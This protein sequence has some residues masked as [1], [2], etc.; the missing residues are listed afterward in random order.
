MFRFLR[1]ENLVKQSQQSISCPAINSPQKDG[2][3]PSESSSESDGEIAEVSRKQRMFARKSIRRDRKKQKEQQKKIENNMISM[4]DYLSKQAEFKMWLKEEKQ[5]TA[6]DLKSPKLKTYFKDFMKLWNKKKLPQK[7]YR[8]STGTDTPPPSRNQQRFSFV[9][10]SPFSDIPGFHH[11]IDLSLEGAVLLDSPFS[12]FGKSP[13]DPLT[14]Q[15]TPRIIKLPDIKDSGAVDK[16][17][18]STD[19]NIQKNNPEP[20]SEKKK[21]KSKGTTPKK[22]KL[23]NDNPYKVTVLSWTSKGELNVSP[24]SPASEEKQ[25]K[26]KSSKPKPPKR[27][28]QSTKVRLDTSVPYEEVKD[29]N[30]LE[31]SDYDPLYADPDPF[32]SGSLSVSRSKSLDSGLHVD[33]PRPVTDGC[34]SVEEIYAVPVKKKRMSAEKGKVVEEVTSPPPPLPPKRK[35]PLETWP[36]Q[37]INNAEEAPVFSIKK[38]GHEFTSPAKISNGSKSVFS[39]QKMESPMRMAVSMPDLCDPKL[40]EK[41]DVDSSSSSS[42]EESE[43]ESFEIKVKILD[44]EVQAFLDEDLSTLPPPPDLVSDIY[45]PVRLSLLPPPPPELL[46]DTPPMENEYRPSIE[47]YGS[48]SSLI[49]ECGTPRSSKVLEAMP[50]Y[51]CTTPKSLLSLDCSSTETP[52]PTL[53]PITPLALPILE[54]VNESEETPQD[55]EPNHQSKAPENSVLAVPVQVTQVKEMSTSSRRVSVGPVLVPPP[56]K[57]KLHKP[58][59][60]QLSSESEASMDQKPPSTGDT[61]NHN[62]LTDALTDLDTSTEKDDVFTYRQALSGAMKSLK[63][64][65]ASSIEDITADVPRRHRNLGKGLNTNLYT[66]DVID[67]RT[68]PKHDTRNRYHSE[69][70]AEHLKRTI[71]EMKQSEGSSSSTSSSVSENSEGHEVK[72]VMKK[73]PVLKPK[74]NKSKVAEAV[75]KARQRQSSSDRSSVSSSASDRGSVSSLASDRSSRSSSEVSSEENMQRKPSNSSGSVSR[76]LGSLNQNCVNRS[77]PSPKKPARTFSAKKTSG[78]K[79][80]SPRTPLTPTGQV[81]SILKTTPVSGTCDREGQGQNFD[82]KA[83]CSRSLTEKVV[84]Q[85]RPS[86]GWDVFET[87]IDSVLDDDCENKDPN[88]ASRGVRETDLDRILE[89]MQSNYPLSP[90]LSVDTASEMNI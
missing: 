75:E 70:S 34:K 58:D 86:L 80:Q 17:N 10:G 62:Y 22:S 3:T 36:Y 37:V 83:S 21:K 16:E 55:M 79:P 76:V 41:E 11:P 35:S 61:P 31:I 89:E 44:P 69:N 72:K 66:E 19:G 32:F 82:R 47:A 51:C 54:A 1:R 7:Y 26:K 6:A 81:R 77:T 60:C 14:P 18:S 33:S 28:S 84:E 74:P 67:Q 71:Q 39:P 13:G 90:L 25:G 73:P 59:L 68:T 40:D 46:M 87:D 29:A 12:T 38:N 49:A 50:S 20:V 43:P 48:Q 45:P 42:D 15:S 65:Y 78:D 53:V 4:E 57:S 85:T 64:A 88:C 5:K 23:K 52:P 56:M 63:T 9:E 8:G 27:T 2:A 30:P 24:A